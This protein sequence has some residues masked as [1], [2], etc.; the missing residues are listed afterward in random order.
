MKY[1]T[2][3]KREIK[4]DAKVKVTGEARYVDDLVVKD[5]LIGKV[6]RSPYGHARI[7][8]IDTSKAEALPGVKVV[9]TFKDTPKIPFNTAGFPP[10]EGAILLEDQYILADKARFVGDPIA[11]VAAVDEDTAREALELIEVEYE[12]LP[13]ILDGLEAFENKDV[14]IHDERSKDNICGRIPMVIGD[15]EKG[16]AEADYIFEDTY[17]TQKVYQCSM[18]P[19]GAALAEIDVNGRIRIYTST[20]MP[21]LVR[22]ITAKSLGM[23][24]RDIQIIK[25]YVG[26]AFGSRLGV[27]N[28]PI[29]ALLAKKAGRPVKLV[30][31]R[32]ESFFTESR[33]PAI[34]TLKTGVK[35]DG[36]FTARY[37]KAIVDTG[38]YATHGPSL[39]A[40]LGGWFI[41]MYKTPAIQFEGYTVYTNTPPCGAFRGYGNPQATF[42]VESQIDQI[43]REL[44]LDPIEIRLKNHPC[45][46][47]T[48][49]WSQMP[50]ESCGL[51]ECMKRAAISIGWEEKRKKKKEETGTK[52][53]GVGF[54]YMMHVSGARPMLHEI[55]SA[56][57]KINEDG[58]VNLI[59]SCSD[60]GTGSAT[61]LTQIAAE[62]LGVR[63]EDVIITQTADTDT[64]P[65][66]IGSHASRQIYSG[67]YAVKKAAEQAKSGVLKIAAEMMNCKP[68]ELDT[69]DGY[70]YHKEDPKRRLT[71]AEVSKEAH[72]GK[73]GHQ[74]MGMAS[75]EPPGN[76]PVYAV[77]FA[78]VE[79]DIETGKVDVLKVA[80]AHD[81]GTAI[82]PPS[83]EGQIEGALQQG[84]GYAL[85]ETMLYASDGRP[86]NA[87]FS[88]YKLLTSMD[89]P[90]IDSIIVEASS[91]TGA[92]GC[93][94]IGES[95][96]VA[97]AAA[98]ANAIYDAVGV[99]IK[100]LPIT[101]EKLLAALKEKE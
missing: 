101:P 62:T 14:L 100:E 93:K 88:D 40:V 19:C 97:T 46:G 30:Y 70:V 10:S 32:H 69:K 25:P 6:L 47:E 80:A 34:M 66:D 36:T 49:L 82:H 67:G 65:F 24:I 4:V 12:P 35:K 58:S 20:Q 68:D 22:S 72:F 74:I 18:E 78:E 53:R 81:A 13:V 94:S 3:G 15:L 59:Y 73:H 76:P 33:H 16:F 38:A 95:G 27:V 11:A 83:V 71:I 79:V 90:E 85:T 41:G 51:E 61:A 77:Q 87:N 7:L 92:Y 42:A 60:V 57:V 8:K 17:R 98:I 75:T 26:G 37:M 2:I 84:I 43:A 99:R 56:V 29:V 44:G 28:E 91:K 54:G 50:I 5:M 45:K 52:R 63:Y 9:V 89:M 48:W 55:S 21:H 1:S 39:T 64:A 31:D 23:P 86:L 96:L